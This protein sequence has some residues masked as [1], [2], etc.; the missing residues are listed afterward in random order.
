MTWARRRPKKCCT[1]TDV[2]IRY[3]SVCPTLTQARYTPHRNAK[4]CPSR[5]R[6]QPRRHTRHRPKREGAPASLQWSAAIFGG[7]AGRPCVFVSGVRAFSRGRAGGK[8]VNK[9]V[10][11]CVCVRGPRRVSGV[12]GCRESPCTVQCTQWPHWAVRYALRSAL[13]AHA[14]RSRRE[15]PEVPGALALHSPRCKCLAAVAAC[16]G[17]RS[18]LA[19]SAGTAPR[20][21][22]GC[23]GVSRRVASLTP[24]CKQNKQTHSAQTRAHRH[25]LEKEPRR[26]TQQNNEQMEERKCNTEKE[27]EERNL[28][29]PPSKKKI[30]KWLY[31]SRNTQSPLMFSLSLV[32]LLSLSEHHQTKPS[33]LV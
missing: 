24:R 4:T 8:E 28:A 33:T 25:T 30:Y 9:R 6:R 21:L 17:R 1:K 7:W 29:L 13:H 14:L 22:R 5:Q 19:G 18:S 11:A 26:K 23:R 27:S 10:C 2:P 32:S 15:Y 3:E 16:S 31:Y 20:V 12:G